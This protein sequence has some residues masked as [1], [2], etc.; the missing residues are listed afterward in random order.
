ME[1]EAHNPILQAHIAASE[2]YESLDSEITRQ[3]VRKYL[4]TNATILQAEVA[5][6]QQYQLALSGD[7]VAMAKVVEGMNY[8]LKLVK[9]SMGLR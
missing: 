7:L 9:R 1:I 8:W 5:I 4:A 2:A 6:E 3:R